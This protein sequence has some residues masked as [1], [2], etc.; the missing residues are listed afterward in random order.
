MENKSQ[1][2]EK[3]EKLRAE[4]THH[5]KLYYV[6]DSPEISDYEYDMMYASLLRLEEENPEF[7]SPDSPTQR[8]GGAPLEKFSK[9]THT[10]RM[11]SLSDVF[12]Y[13]ELKAF[14]DSVRTTLPE[15]EYSVEPKIDG[16]SVSL[17]YE[18][19][20]FVQGATRGDGITGEDV[21]QNI[22]TI[23]SIP[24]TLPEPLNLTVR[25]EVYMPRSV[26]NRINEKRER[27]GQALMA[28]PRNAAAGSLR[29]LD[30]SVAASR[31]LDIFIFNFQEGELYAD[32]REALS[33]TEILDRLS[34]LGFPTVPMRTKASCYEDIITHIDSIGNARDSLAYD[35]D[36]VV[37]K[38]DRLADR[39][40]LGEGTNTPKWAVA[41]KFPPEEKVTTLDR[42]SV[43]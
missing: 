22:K 34:S 3:I 11:D 12:S 10:V 36:G 14:C 21:T 29:Q 26:F 7:F 40:T 35:I 23:F 27:E 2:K 41:Y 30:P 13:D 4:L 6:Y 17:K 42:K 8:V 43:V 32:G 31:G 5:A 39:V 33:H 25:G 20:V 16:L 38:A 9:V 1:I 19:G 24:M 37:I 18:N 15:I 28:N